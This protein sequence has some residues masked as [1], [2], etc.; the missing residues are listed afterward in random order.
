MRAKWLLFLLLSALSLLVLAGC[1]LLE[2]STAAP[3]PDVPAPEGGTLVIAVLTTPANQ[4]GSFQFTGV[5]T[6][7]IPSGGTLVVADLEPGTYTSTQ[8]DPAPDFDVS[9]VSCDDGES[10]VPSS[11]DASSRTAV[12]N[13]E[14]G[15]TI[16][17]T[18]TNT[19]RGSAVISAQTV[20]E[21]IGG[22]F[23]FTGVPTGTIPANGT[24][25]VANL[26]P[27]TY[28]S[29]EVDPAPQ[30]DVTAV[31]CDDGGSSTPSS[32]DPGSRTAVFNVD[33]GEMVH[34]TFTNTRRGAAVIAS[35]TIPSGAEGLFQF[36]GVPSG[37]IPGNGTLVVADLQPG[38][39]TSTE[40]DPA[41]D[42]E[43]TEVTCN[44]GA[45]AT[46]SSGDAA[47]RTAIFNVDPGETVRC[48]FT[49]ARPGAEITPTLTAGGTTGEPGTGESPP[50]TGGRNPFADPD[51]AM[52]NFPLPD[53]LPPDAGTYA[54]PKPGPWS[55]TNYQGQLD[56][57]VTN[58]TIPA[59]PPESG[60]LEV[61]DGGETVVG[62]GVQE[63]QASITLYAHAEITGRYSGSF[64][65]AEQ[66]VPVT[67]AYYW[68]VITDEHIVGFL[69][70]SVDSQ[71]V[72]CT[73]YRSFEMFYT[74]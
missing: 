67:I 25:V 30:F 69:T 39:Y 11:G 36:T 22:S 16:R 18:F 73:V 35:E 63:G 55:V 74:G 7:T 4:A 62:T 51:D 28:S 54:V 20:P 17:C 57:G 42:F 2:Q 43:I 60:T 26:E 64:Q 52:V 53:D 50:S 37:T 14:A 27:G 48:L 33:A 6:G 12:F 1:S 65:G 31:S 58:L 15:E 24:L 34:C 13:V 21:G 47:T 3:T 38:T 44:D 71:G 66:G 41:P 29:T 61:L 49:N 46:A 10:A 40:V 56:C 59:S 9:A 45:S 32:G 19:Q 23:Q 8:V 72:T 68:Q 5:P 70:A